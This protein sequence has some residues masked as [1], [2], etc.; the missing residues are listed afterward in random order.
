MFGKY[1]LGFIGLIIVIIGLIPLI[2]GLTKG[3][4]NEFWIG[5]GVVFF[6]GYLRYSMSPPLLCGS[7]C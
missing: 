4:S 6:G 5:L 1:V 2:I 7:C 3:F